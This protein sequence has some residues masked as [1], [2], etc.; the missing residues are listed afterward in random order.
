MLNDDS[1]CLR[2][3]YPLKHLLRNECPECGAAFDPNT[4]RT[5]DLRPKRRIVFRGPSHA[6]LVLGSAVILAPFCWL[7]VWGLVLTW[8]RSSYVG[9]L[10]K[11]ILG[12]ALSV[13]AIFMFVS[14]WRAIDDD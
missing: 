12:G 13:L 1:V 8:P 9:D 10:F 14:I 11:L 4:R 2:C 3:G 6:F 7:F 5:Y